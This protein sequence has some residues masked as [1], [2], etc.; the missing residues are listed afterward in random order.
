VWL[1]AFGVFLVSHLVGDFLLQTETQALHKYGGLGRDGL[2]RRAL[3]G[4]AG[5]YSAAFLPAL[6]WLGSEWGW[7][8][9]ALLPLIGVPHLLQDDGRALSV[10]IERVKHSQSEPGDLLFTLVDQSFHVVALFGAA[11]ASSL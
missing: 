11:L 10:W 8:E 2:K 4:H 5:V 6:V 1:E 9:L 7:A 3:F